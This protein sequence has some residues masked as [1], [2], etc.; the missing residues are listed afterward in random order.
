[1]ALVE[2]LQELGLTKREAEVYL[3]ILAKK[4]ATVKDLLDYLDI[5]QPQLYNIIQSLIRKGFI[6]ASA[7]RPRIYTATDIGSLIEVQKIKL[8]ILKTTLE[9]ELK[10]ISLTSEEE[11][12]YISLVRG[13]EGVV[14]G[15]LEVINSAQ[16]EIRAEMP[17]SIFQEIKPY[18]LGAL[19]RGVNLYLLVYPRMGPI[20]EFEQYRDQLKIKTSELGNFLLVISDLS[21]A[22]YSKRRFFSVHRAP[23]SSTEIYGYIIH[24]KDLLLRLLNIHNNLWVKAKEVLCWKPRPEIYPKLFIEF[25]MVLD[26]L[27]A[28][29]RLGYLPIVSVEGRDIKEG[30]YITLNGAVK[31]VNRYGIVSNFVLENESGIFTIGGFDAELEDVEAQLVTIQKVE[32]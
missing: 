11:A 13:L 22:I 23:I 7:G 17:Y 3:T 16:V 32:R 4:G 24:E 5:H 6:R 21:S 30:N 27:E 28:L 31:S 29:L 2:R 9:E 8:D 18:L 1:M 25:S 26:E 20:E 14:S 12:P 10:K 19:Q 15:I